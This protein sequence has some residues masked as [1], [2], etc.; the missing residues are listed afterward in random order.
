MDVLKH[1]METLHKVVQAHRPIGNKW[2]LKQSSK[3]GSRWKLFEL[4]I[5]KNHYQDFSSCTTIE[6]RLMQD[7]NKLVNMNDVLARASEL[8]L[9]TSGYLTETILSK[10]C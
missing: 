1:S 10:E 4:E 9:F 2:G 5:E 3:R 7:K 6:K 8:Q